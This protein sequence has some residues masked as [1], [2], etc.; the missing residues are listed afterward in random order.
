MISSMEQHLDEI[1]AEAQVAIREDAWDDAEILIDSWI[2]DY[3]NWDR[4]S[5]EHVAKLKALLAGDLD[6][7]E[8]LDNMDTPAS[9]I[10]AFEEAEI[11][12]WIYLHNIGKVDTVGSSLL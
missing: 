9:T 1:I 4:G 2:Y 5:Q 8:C 7:Q 6:A 11:C 12:A 10:C 3:G